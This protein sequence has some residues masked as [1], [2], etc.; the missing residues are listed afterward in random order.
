M[1]VSTTARPRRIDPRLLRRTRGSR[2]ALAVD[3]ALGLVAA[4]LVLAQAVLIAHIAARSFDGTELSALAVPLAAL[5]IVVTARAVA[6][7]GFDV[8]GRLAAVDVLSSLRGDLVRSRLGDH[9]AGIDARDDAELAV[10]A[11][12]GIDALETVFARSLPQLVLAAVVPAAVLLLVAVIDPVSALLM[13]VTLPLVPVFMWL[14]GRTT[15]RRAMARWQELSVLSSHFLDVVRG[16]PTLRA[17][18]RGEAQA[19]R[20]DQVGERYRKATM[21]TLRLAF[22]SGAVLDLAATLGVALI[23][24]TVGVRLVNGDL[25]FEPALTVLLLAPELYLPL[26]N[27]GA[28]FHA[29]AD[30]MAVAGRLLDAVEA[31]PAQAAAPLAIPASGTVR[32]DRVTFRYPRAD[33]AALDGVGLELEPGETVALV[34]PSGSGKSTVARLLLRLAEP[35]G[36]RIL[37]GGTD[38]AD[39]DPDQWRSRIAWLPQHPTLLHGTIADNIRLGAPDAP[40]ARVRDA[41]LTAGADGFISQL[42]AGYQTRVG[43]GGRPLSAG[44]TQRI[45]LAR[46]LLRD[47]PL[48][49][50]DEPTANLDAGSAELVRTAVDRCC[51]R[52]RTVLVIGHDDELAE[53]ADRVVRLQAVAS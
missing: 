22:L 21:E 27:L 7:W 45:A 42:P 1:P 15:E 51:R 4:L 29:G 34:G 43:D 41:A 18:N 24:V 48:L 44:E 20:V 28:Q 53:R 40:D 33:L 19:E 13:L 49:I 2:L 31:P 30:G 36:G 11:V 39:C 14:I 52:G 16:L 26:R 17:F 47:A 25:G 32:F 23:A 10:A 5:C 6:S 8:V 12:A 37:V 3:A 35:S 50:L 46:A 9:P 38:I